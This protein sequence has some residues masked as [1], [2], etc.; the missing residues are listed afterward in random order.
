[1]TILYRCSLNIRRSFFFLM[2]AQVLL[3]TAYIILLVG[4][5]RSAIAESLD[6]TR[7]LFKTGQYTQC[8]ES[9][10]NAVRDTAFD[11][12][13]I[14]NRILMIETLMVLGR[15]EQAANEIDSALLSYPVSIRLLRLGHTAYQ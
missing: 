1:M 15:Y 14:A 3:L 5:N 10:R 6:V 7:E 2:K 12:S 4:L 8:L 11:K 13:A 9:L